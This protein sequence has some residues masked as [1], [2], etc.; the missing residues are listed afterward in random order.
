MGASQLV[1]CGREAATGDGSVVSRESGEMAPST[2]LLITVSFPLRSL[3]RSCRHWCHFWTKPV[4]EA[5]DAS[6]LQGFQG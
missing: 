5:G 4:L 1:R 3:P 6:Y 2:P